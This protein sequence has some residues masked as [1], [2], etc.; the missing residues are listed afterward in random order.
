MSEL[1]EVMTKGLWSRIDQDVESYIKNCYACQTVVTKHSSLP[2]KVT[3]LITNEVLPH[4][5]LG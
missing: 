3:E 2:M 1:T 4:V 5:M